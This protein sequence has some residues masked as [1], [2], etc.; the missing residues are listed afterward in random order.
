MNIHHRSGRPA[1]RRPMHR[2]GMAHNN[3]STNRD[4]NRVTQIAP[5]VDWE[6]MNNMLFAEPSESN[7]IAAIDSIILTAFAF[8]V[9][10]QQVATS[11]MWRDF[12]N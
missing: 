8:R 7:A 6:R 5:I 1:R 9:M 10:G 4:A 2:Q 12:F 11:S 3:S